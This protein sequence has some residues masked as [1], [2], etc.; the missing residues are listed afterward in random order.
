MEL[1]FAD[2]KVQDLCSSRT[3]L[4]TEYGAV[5]ARKI[6]CRLAMLAAAP[7]LACVPTSLPVGLTRVGS[8]G[9]FAVAVGET[10]SLVFQPLPK[11]TSPM[12]DLSQFSKVLIIALVANAAA[13][14]AT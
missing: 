14:A 4:V 3:A 13:K 11:E 1:S 7:T 8:H 6:C 5:L 9:S 2:A 12:S 10:H